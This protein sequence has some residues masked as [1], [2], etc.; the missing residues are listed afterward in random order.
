MRF[1]NIHFLKKIIYIFKNKKEGILKHYE[2]VIDSLIYIY[3]KIII[4]CK[5]RD[6]LFLILFE[7]YSRGFTYKVFCKKPYTLLSAL[8][9]FKEI[10]QC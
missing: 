9:F 1:K 3:L 6:N 10:F 5:L 8:H 4:K 7:L 2:I